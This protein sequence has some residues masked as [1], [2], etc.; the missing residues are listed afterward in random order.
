MN[1]VCQK[2]LSVP[3]YVV[4]RGCTLIFTV[5]L[6]RFVLNSEITKMAIFACGIVVVGT[7][8]GS[9]NF[10]G[11]MSLTTF[12]LLAGLGSSFMQGC[13]NVSS[14]ALLQSQHL[15]DE[16]SSAGDR[17]TW[18]VAKWS[19]LLCWIM[20]ILWSDYPDS[21]YGLKNLPW[22]SMTI[23][24]VLSFCVNL[25]AGEAMNR[26]SAITFNLTGYIKSVLQAFIA[27]LLLGE[28]M[29]GNEGIALVITICGSV[30]YTYSQHWKILSTS[31]GLSPKT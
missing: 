20:T 29:R 9:F 17:R 3:S 28:P 18:I 16:S 21:L 2:Y 13:Y 1:S 14:K 15:Q 26:V 12:G 5:L 7:T 8:A 11:G 30:M 10:D 23:G 25:A 22:I 4:A 6:S 27:P 24:G 19:A 31:Q